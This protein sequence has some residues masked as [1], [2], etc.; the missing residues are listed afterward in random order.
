MA[1]HILERLPDCISATAWVLKCVVLWE[2]NFA[3]VCKC[4]RS[5]LG[6]YLEPLSSV[7]VSVSVLKETASCIIEPVERSL[8][9][10]LLSSILRRRQIKRA[11]RGF[12]AWLST[13]FS[14]VRCPARLMRELWERYQETLQDCWQSLRGRLQTPCS[15]LHGSII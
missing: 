13:S 8:F 6:D 14:L 1:I 3:A 4:A 10:L 9:A 7:N 5:V 15:E 12:Y 2:G 11:I